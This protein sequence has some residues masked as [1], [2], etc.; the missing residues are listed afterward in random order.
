M[1]KPIALFLVL[2]LSIAVYL[3]IHKAP[4]SSKDHDFNQPRIA[5][6]LKST[7]YEF[8][9]A[10]EDAAHREAQAQGVDAIIS[11]ETRA[12]DA[13]EQ[14][15]L[16]ETMLLQKPQAMIVGADNLTNLQSCLKK[17]TAQGIPVVDIDG[18]ISEESAKQYGLNVAFS[19]AANNYLLGQKAA[20]YLQGQ[21][22]KV[23]ILEGMPGSLPSIERKKGFLEHLPPG[24]EVV[25]S[26][27]TDWDRLKAVE[28]TA[29]TL[30]NHPDLKVVFA[31]ADAMALG[32][33]EGARQ[34]GADVAKNLVIIG[35]DGNAEAIQ[36]IKDGKMD[37]SIAQ[38]PG[39]MMKEAYAKTLRL[40]KG[41]TFP[42]QQYLP[43]LVLTQQLLQK[44]DDPLMQYVGF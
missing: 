40:L 39:L 10:I 14:L 32:A 31:V 35:V 13:Q 22:G 24:L 30:T 20:E 8:W 1:P 42:F 25:A 7:T 6:L 2:A 21:T 34:K 26:L 5:V 27:P 3:Y 15:N 9:K 38:L 17:A 11:A 44:S 18:N 4:P 19:V 23:L 43:T 41:E 29:D 12:N 16:C 28:I 36:A 37:A 33:Y